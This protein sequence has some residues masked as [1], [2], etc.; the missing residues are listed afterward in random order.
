MKIARRRTL[1]ISRWC[2]KKVQVKENKCF[3]NNF[4]MTYKILLFFA[5]YMPGRAK[6]YLLPTLRRC[7][8]GVQRPPAVQPSLQSDFLHQSHLSSCLL[9]GVHVHPP[10]ANSAL[11]RSQHCLASRNVDPLDPLHPCGVVGI[12]RGT[13]AAVRTVQLRFFPPPI[14]RKWLV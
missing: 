12:L 10:P 1:S 6:L 13:T 9:F 3:G 7:L 2:S 8:C 14:V 4:E 5:S 11:F